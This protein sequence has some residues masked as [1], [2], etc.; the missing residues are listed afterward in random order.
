M[1][2][3]STFS[4]ECVAHASFF[5]I[6]DAARRRGLAI[7]QIL[8]HARLRHLP[9]DVLVLVWLF[10]LLLFI[11]LVLAGDGT[12]VPLGGGPCP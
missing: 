6:I 2:E 3:T 4:F 5:D 10:A 12:D 8:V 11:I 1:R 9:P 7:G